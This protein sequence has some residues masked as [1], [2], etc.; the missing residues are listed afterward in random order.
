MAKCERLPCGEVPLDGKLDQGG[1]GQNIKRLGSRRFDACDRDAL[2]DGSVPDESQWGR[3]AS[4][5]LRFQHGAARTRQKEGMALTKGLSSGWVAGTNIWKGLWGPVA[6]PEPYARGQ[7]SLLSQ[8][9]DR[10]TFPGRLRTVAFAQQG[11][12]RSGHR[13]W[14]A[15]AA[16]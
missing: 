15:R 3:R 7:D 14:A 10:F 8:P 6:S 11:R 2:A 9:P 4:R 13:F 1:D 5:A 12:A 16:V